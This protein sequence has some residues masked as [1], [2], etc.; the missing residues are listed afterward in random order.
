MTCQKCGCSPCACSPS[1]LNQPQ[2]V[3]GVLDGS[4]LNGPVINGGQANNLALVGAIIDCTT[5]AC[6]QPPGINNN[7]IATTAFVNTAIANSLS[8]SNP[9]FCQAVADCAMSVAGAL[10]PT[11]FQCL[12]NTD[13][14]INNTNAFGP[15]SYASQ[16][17]YGVTRYATI[18][19]LGQAQCLLSIEPCTLAEFWNTPNLASPLWLAFSNAV[20]ML[21]A[22]TNSPVFTGDPQ[23]PT[24][25]A[26]DCDTSIATT[27]FVCTAITNAISAGNP[28][29]CAAVAACAGGGT[30][31]ASVVAL[32]AS[33]GGNPGASVGFLGSD[34]MTYTAA[35]IVAA[36]GGGSGGNASSVTGGSC[37]ISGNTQINWSGP[38]FGAVNPTGFASFT[39]IFFLGSDNSGGSGLTAVLEIAG[40]FCLVLAAGALIGPMT[41]SI[42]NSQA[43]A[44]RAGGPCVSASQYPDC[45]GA[46]F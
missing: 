14:I 41:Y 35:Q 6:T 44:W 46:P 42:P 39:S 7:T 24:P 16:T 21:A 15:S 27:A 36:A 3:G 10:C 13:G 43:Q 31:C 37:G 28:A 25:A 18:T 17:A 2:I 33:A 22:T 34:C 45:S 40:G 26:G 23:A 5:Q 12:E 29:F 1:V 11:I 38:Y 30:D 19:E 8:G 4:T 9:L 32:F 20:S